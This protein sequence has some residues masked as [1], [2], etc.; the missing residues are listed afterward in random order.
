MTLIKIIVSALCLTVAVWIAV[1]K[2][3]KIRKTQ[4]GKGYT[5]FSLY[6]YSSLYYYDM[7][8]SIGLLAVVVLYDFYPRPDTYGWFVTFYLPSL[9]FGIA[10]FGK[11]IDR[12]L[13]A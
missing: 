10:R 6:D 4:K 12:S 3:R 9:C 11:A 7:Y 2:I 5:Y 1:Y 13:T 8:Y